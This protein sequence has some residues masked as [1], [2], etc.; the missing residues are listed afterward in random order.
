MTAQ[1]QYQL[2]AP[3]TEAK[4]QAGIRIADPQ[5]QQTARR[6]RRARPLQNVKLCLRSQVMQHIQNDHC[7]GCSE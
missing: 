5:Q 4:A 6:E 7:I 1:Q 3:L 2:V